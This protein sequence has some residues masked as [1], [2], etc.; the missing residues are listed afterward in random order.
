M[1]KGLS[2]ACSK[3]FW[4]HVFVVFVDP[5]YISSC[6]HASQLYSVPEDLKV[7]QDLVSQMLWAQIQKSLSWKAAVFQRYET[8]PWK[9]GTGEAPKLRFQ[10]GFFF[11]LRKLANSSKIHYCS[12]NF[13]PCPHFSFFFASVLNWQTKLKHWR[14]PWTGGL[15]TYTN[16]FSEM[17]LLLSV[18]SVVI[19]LSPALVAGQCP[20]PLCTRS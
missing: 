14:L 4:L 7:L 6:Q 2:R 9:T 19:Y 11:S 8:L 12:H 5:G 20:F 13:L 18:R 15:R 17:S 16:I 3:V 1:C 10:A